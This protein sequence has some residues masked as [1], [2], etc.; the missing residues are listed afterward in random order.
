MCDVS[1]LWTSHGMQTEK[2][3]VLT[4]TYIMPVG[5]KKM[6]VTQCVHGITTRNI[7]VALAN[8]K[9]LSLDRK[10]LDPRRPV[11]KPSPVRMRTLAGFLALECSRLRRFT[12]G[13]NAH[14]TLPPA[15][16]HCAA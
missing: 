16:S 13:K 12:S 10:F 15:L 7:L 1:L 5:V 14:Q 6:D 8:D 4:Q 2:P 9:V 3:R 11:G